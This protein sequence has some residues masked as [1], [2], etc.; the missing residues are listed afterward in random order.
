MSKVGPLL[1]R[2]FEIDKSFDFTPFTTGGFFIFSM[3]RDVS[4]YMYLNH[5]QKVFASILPSILPCAQISSEAQ[6]K[7]FS[8]ETSLNGEIYASSTVPPLESPLPVLLP[9][10]PPLGID[11]VILRLPPSSDTAAEA[12]R[13]ERRDYKKKREREKRDRED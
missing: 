3:T 13:E 7:L 2:R 10:L 1:D 8:D 9:S 11:I 5:G 6:V 4:K 12:K